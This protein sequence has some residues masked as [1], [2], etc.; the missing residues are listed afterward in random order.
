MDGEYSFTA[1]GRMHHTT[2]LEV[3]GWLNKAWAST[4][5]ILSG[6]RKVGII[7]TA[8]DDNSDESD[9]EEEAPLRLPQELA[10]Y[11]RSDTE[12]EAF[13]MTWSET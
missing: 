2:F 12:D 1:T 3:I 11:F 10:E 6:F 4:K 9:T 8:T 7:G 5:I 13:R